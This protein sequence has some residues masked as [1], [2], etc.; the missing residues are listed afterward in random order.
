MILRC[1][2]IGSAHSQFPGAGTVAEKCI[3]RRVVRFF[4]YFDHDGCVLFYTLVNLCRIIAICNEERDRLF[5]T[6]VRGLRRDRLNDYVLRDRTIEAGI[7]MIF[8][9]LMIF[10]VNNV[11]GVHVRGF[12][13][14]H[15][16]TFRSPPRV[17]CFP[18]VNSMRY[19]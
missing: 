2:L 12:L 11:V 9:P 14:W 1:C 6:H 18:F 19:F 13:N 15:R 16:K 7:C 4:I 8:S 5:L 3:T 10:R 17:F